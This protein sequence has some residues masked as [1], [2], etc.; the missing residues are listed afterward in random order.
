MD[1]GNDKQT[2]NTFHINFAPHF[3]SIKSNSNE[4]E[5]NQIEI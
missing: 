1:D 2:F 3:F 4:Y 5:S